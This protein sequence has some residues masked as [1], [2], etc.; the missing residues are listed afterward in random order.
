MRRTFPSEA[1]STPAEDS[2]GE[3]LVSRHP[4]RA[5][6]RGQYD[7]REPAVARGRSRRRS[8]LHL[9]WNFAGTVCGSID[10]LP[11]MPLRDRISGREQERAIAL[12]P[13]SRLA[14]RCRACLT[15]S[16]TLQE[17]PCRWWDRF[18]PIPGPIFLHFDGE[19]A[20]SDRSGRRHHDGTQLRMGSRSA[21]SGSRAYRHD[22]PRRRWLRSTGQRPHSRHLLRQVISGHGPRHSRPTF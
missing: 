9:D 20:T 12:M 2:I 11:V 6:F 5:I 4:F 16:T 22:H 13:T 14:V 10:Q 19:F 8:G 15:A 3:R 18:S 21:R 7:W 17:I 1:D